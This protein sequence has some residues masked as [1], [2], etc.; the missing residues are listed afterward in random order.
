VYAV[1]NYY[2]SG[3]SQPLIEKWNGTKFA[4]QSVSL[5]SGCSY[6]KLYSVSFTSSSNG[7]AVGICSSPSPD[8]Y[9]IYHYDGTSWSSTV[10]TGN[11][12]LYSVKAIS[13]SEAWAV[14]QKAG[15]PWKPYI[16]HYTTSGGWQEDTSISFSSTYAS[17]LN[18]VDV[19]GANDV[20]AVG[21]FNGNNTLALH[22]NGSS[23]LQ[24]DTSFISAPSQLTG[25]AVNSNVAWLGGGT[26]STANTPLVLKSQ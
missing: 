6:V 5:P 17:T 11:A 8:K 18:S 7:W 13:A 10:G 22:Y 16:L 12:R 3:T 1:G 9:V 14:G 25:V 2:G 23:W 15:T 4:N 24:V 20:W 26:G 19:D 21:V